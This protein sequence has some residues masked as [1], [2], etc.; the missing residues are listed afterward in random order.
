M[1]I[2]VIDFLV[3]NYPST[4]NGVLGRPQLKTMKAVTS[5]HY[6]TIKFPT[7][8]RT[9]QIQGRYWNSRECYNKS[10]AS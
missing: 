3:V 10:L 1:V 7:T 8:M 4:F 6:M 2:V 9:D 5:I